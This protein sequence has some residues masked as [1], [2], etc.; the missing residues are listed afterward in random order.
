MPAL[1]A[2]QTGVPFGRSADPVEHEPDPLHAGDVRRRRHPE[3]RRAARAQPVQRDDRRGRH[4]DQHLTLAP[5]RLG[6]L[7][8]APRARRG[9]RSARP[10]SRSPS[11]HGSGATDRLFRS[12]DRKMSFATGWRSSSASCPISPAV[13]ASS[14]NPRSS[15]SGSPRSASAAPH[16]PAPLSGSVLPSTCGCTRPIAANSAR[17]GPNRPSSRA[18]CIRRGVRGS[19]SLCTWWPRPGTNRPA[20]RCAGT[21]CSASASQPASSVGSS[22]RA[23]HLVQEPAGVL[24]DAEEPRAPAEQPGGQRALDRVGR[25]QVGQPRDDRGRG[26]PVVGQRREHRLEHPHLAGLGPALRGQPERQLA[27]PDLA[28]HVAGQVVAEQ[29]DRVAG[30]TRPARSGTRRSDRARSRRPATCRSSGAVLVQLGRRQRVAAPG[31]RRS[32]IGCRA[33]GTARSPSPTCDDRLQPELLGHREPAVDRVDRPARHARRRRAARTTRR[34]PASPAARRGSACS[35]ARFTVRSRLRANR[36]SS[37]TS[38]MPSTSHS[39]RNS[40]S[41]AAATIRSRSAVGQRLVGEDARVGVAHAVGHHA[42]RRR[43]PSCG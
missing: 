4:G 39:L 3:V 29:G 23:Q 18:I 41:L 19:P 17:C 8:A 11:V 5:G 10:A 25:R 42:A 26:E 32:V 13:R 20:A 27:E 2:N 38:G 33:I 14:A 43:R 7:A 6:A 15:G 36:G 9:S 22:H 16:T 35:S 21:V 31:S 1:V 28:H 30:S 12:T 24:G 34:R 40:R 37:A